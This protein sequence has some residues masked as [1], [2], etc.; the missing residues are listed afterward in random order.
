MKRAAIPR[1]HSLI[2]L[3]VEGQTEYQ[4]VPE[5]LRRLGIRH[6]RPS[7][8]HGQAPEASPRTL[9]EKWLLPHVRVQ[10]AKGADLVVVVL[11]AESRHVPVGDFEEELR[12]ELKRRVA[13]VEGSP[14]ADRVE[15]AVCNRTFENWLLAD[16]RGIRKCEYVVCDLSRVVACHA[17]G[18]DALA[19]LRRA[20][21]KDAWYRKAVHGPR[22]AQ[23]VRVEDA[24]VRLCSESLRGF[25]DKVR[26]ASPTSAQTVGG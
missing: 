3:V 25:L 18:K 13:V 14:A 23:H 26:N 5:M 24:R 6:T 2:G 4:A 1:S 11:D 16:P 22:I 17:D 19:L 15:V 20:L 12:R 7:C 21:R 9:V 8:F 10:L